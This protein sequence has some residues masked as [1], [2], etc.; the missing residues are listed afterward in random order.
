MEQRKS[1][2]KPIIIPPSEAAQ[3][4]AQRDIYVDLLANGVRVGHAQRQN[5]SKFY[6]VTAAGYYQW[7]ETNAEIRRSFCAEGGWTLDDTDNRPMLVNSEHQIRF[8]AAGGNSATGLT[9]DTP[10]VANTKGK[11]TIDSVNAKNGLSSTD[12]LF[13]LEQVS[14][15][16]T[17]LPPQGEWLLLYF[18]DEHTEELR[19]EFSQPSALTGD[20]EVYAWSVRV[21]LEAIRLDSANIQPDLFSSED[22]GIDFNISRA[23]GS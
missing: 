7:S 12:G 9:I 20:G 18:H 11:A 22:D 4:L 10:D 1:L 23:T 17:K 8:V 13:D 14:T 16:A 21:L 5:C 2:Q 19:C 3:Y 6:P 15:D